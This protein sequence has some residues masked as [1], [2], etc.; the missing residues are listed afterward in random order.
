MFTHVSKLVKRRI[1]KSAGKSKSLECE[2]ES[3]HVSETLHAMENLWFTIFYPMVTLWGFFISVSQPF[4]RS[5][6]LIYFDLP[7]HDLSFNFGWKMYYLAECGFYIQALFSLIFIDQ[8]MKDFLEYLIHH[9]STLIALFLSYTCGY[10]RLATIVLLLHDVTDIF[11]YSS[12]F[13]IEIGNRPVASVLFAGFILC[14]TFLRLM[15]FPYLIYHEIFNKNV[16]V[17]PGNQYFYKYI[18][19]SAGGL[20]LDKYGLCVFHHCISTWRIIIVCSICLLGLHVFWYR[21]A[22]KVLARSFG[23]DPKVYDIRKETVEEE[24][25]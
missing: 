5:T 3:L 2:D 19:E 24:W 17:M 11:L 18:A 25:G 7:Q 10:P 20:D 23:K 14:Y 22:L 15:Y 16:L 13:S 8:R 12:K 9:I 6:D 1:I 21:L 4:F